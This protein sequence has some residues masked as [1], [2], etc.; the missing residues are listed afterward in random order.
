[1]RQANLTISNANRNTGSMRIRAI[2]DDST[3]QT[4]RTDLLAGAVSL[5]AQDSVSF[6]ASAALTGCVQ[7]SD[8]VFKCRSSDGA[9]R[10]TIKVLRDD[11]NI[12]NLT[13]TRRHLPRAQTGVPQPTGPV[14]V[15][16]QQALI[17]RAGAIDVCRKKGNFSLSCRMP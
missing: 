14:A 10:A 4:F 17:Q 9:T 13:L 3:A 6:N 5:N 1:V 15:S 2:V 7:R 12:F 16:M 8:R 11:P